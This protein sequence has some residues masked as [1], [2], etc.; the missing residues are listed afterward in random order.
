VLMMLVIL[1]L[2]RPLNV[3]TVSEKSF[4]TKLL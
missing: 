1:D 4:A 2:G 3:A